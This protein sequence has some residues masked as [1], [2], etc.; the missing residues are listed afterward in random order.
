MNEQS[1]PVRIAQTQVEAF[2]VML[3]QISSPETGEP[4][5][6]PSVNITQETRSWL[7]GISQPHMEDTSYEKTP[8]LLLALDPEVEI[9]ETET[10]RVVRWA[11]SSYRE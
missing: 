2:F 9:E 1:A 7:Y 5:L 6:Q 3:H 4:I 8:P 11:A 10:G